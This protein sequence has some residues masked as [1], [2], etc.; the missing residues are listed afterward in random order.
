VE[1]GT[2]GLKKSSAL[3]YFKPQIIFSDS[4]YRTL[5]RNK[6]NIP[7]SVLPG[8]IQNVE[9]WFSYTV[10]CDF[11]QKRGKDSEWEHNQLDW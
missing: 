1:L 3:L 10:L 11:L 7:F 2:N 9:Y 6:N 5:L 8:L 4:K